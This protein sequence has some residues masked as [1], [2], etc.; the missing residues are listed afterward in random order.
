MSEVEPIEPVA[1]PAAIEKEVVVLRTALDMIGA[2][3]NLSIFGE[4]ITFRDTNL[5]FNHPPSAALFN[6]LLADFL[7]Q[8]G[9]SFFEPKANQNSERR[10]EL[11]FLVHLRRVTANPQ[12]GLDGHHP[13]VGDAPRSVIHCRP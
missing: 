12:L 3:V 2:M 4:V 11:T 9:G 8:P 7:S 1:G 10:S 13:K 5:R 6:I